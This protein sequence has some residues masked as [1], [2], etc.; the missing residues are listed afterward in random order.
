VYDIGGNI[1]AGG[2]QM[3]SC[4]DVARVGA[5]IVQRGVWR[6]AQGEAY[7]M[8]PEWYTSCSHLSMGTDCH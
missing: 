6:N 1:S 3:V 2:G 7:Q 8:M 5:L 4:R